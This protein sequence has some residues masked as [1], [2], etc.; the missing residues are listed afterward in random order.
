MGKR[1]LQPQTSRGRDGPVLLGIRKV[2]AYTDWVNDYF[3]K[4]FT[5]FHGLERTLRQLVRSS[6]DG[7]GLGSA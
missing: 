6:L 2:L 3:A 1:S 4:I 5:N 7:N